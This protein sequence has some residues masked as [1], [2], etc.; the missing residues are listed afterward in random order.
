M[1]GLIAL[2]D[3]ARTDFP[4]LV[5]ELKA[6]GVRTIMVTGDAPTTAAIVARTVGLD[7]AVSPPGI[8]TDVRPEQYSIYAGVRLAIT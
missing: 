7:G 8:A 4:G 5:N 3:P 2:S 6:S 1:V